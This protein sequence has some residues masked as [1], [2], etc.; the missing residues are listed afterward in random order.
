MLV[1]F[2]MQK[3]PCTQ[4][5]AFCRAMLCISVDQCRYAVSVCPSVTFVDSNKT[6]K[7]IFEIFSLSDSQTILV[8]P[9]Q[10]S[11]RHSDR[12]PLTGASNAGEVNTNRDRR[13]YSYLS[14]DDV[15]DVRT[16]SAKIHR[17]VYRTVGD[18]SVKL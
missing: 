14:I 6:N 18:A 9:Y 7:N 17:A 4:V 2:N 11:W 8:F 15:L 16:T 12:D 13:R 3:S 5:N 10:T 1:N